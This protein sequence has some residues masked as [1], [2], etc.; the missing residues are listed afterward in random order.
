MFVI[1]NPSRAVHVLRVMATLS[2]GARA[3]LPG[4]QAG[5]GPESSVRPHETQRLIHQLHHPEEMRL[6]RSAGS[7]FIRARKTFAPLSRLGLCVQFG[8]GRA[9]PFQVC[10]RIHGQYGVATDFRPEIR[11]LRKRDS[12][13][14]D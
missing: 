8:N 10:I 2:S 6:A 14:R 13:E 12:Q 7:Q 4:T 9:Q 11:I 5:A 1:S 3:Q